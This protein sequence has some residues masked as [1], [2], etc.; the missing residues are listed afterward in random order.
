MVRADTARNH[1]RIVGVAVAA[2]EEIGPETTLQQIA[3]QARVSVTT[4]YR[5]F[6][7]RDPPPQGHVR[8]NRA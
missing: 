8:G 2:L 7:N 1:Q 4:L 5:R 6:G 3:E